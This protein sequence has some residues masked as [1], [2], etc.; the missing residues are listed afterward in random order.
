M[1]AQVASLNFYLRRIKMDTLQKESLEFADSFDYDEWGL[2]TNPGKFER[3]PKYTPYFWNMTMLSAQDEDLYG[4]D[5][6]CYSLFHVTDPD[7]AVFPE[8]KDVKVVSLWESENGFVFSD[9][10]ADFED[11]R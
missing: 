10:D 7:R 1:N 5:G 2:I 3:E 9:L 6:T 4:D 11:L 8:L